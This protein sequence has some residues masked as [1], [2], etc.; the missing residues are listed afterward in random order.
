MALMDLIKSRAATAPELRAKLQALRNE[1]PHAGRQAREAARRKALLAGNDSETAKIDA[2]L[3]AMQRDSE[4][5]ALALIDL[6]QQLA[7]AERLELDAERVEVE[8]E[9]EA[10]AARLKKEYPA[11]ANK[12]VDL[13]TK[14]Q[15]AEAKVDAFNQR[16]ARAGRSDAVKSVEWR[17]FEVPAQQYPALYSLLQKTVLRKL[18]G[19]SAGWNDVVL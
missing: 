13:L 17:A 16:L 14:L 10:L 6:Q 8:K 18:P 7:E 1:D 11:A 3:A 9:A 2:E 4:R 19:I 12:I 5:Q 15:A